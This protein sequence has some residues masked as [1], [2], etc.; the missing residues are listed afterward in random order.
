MKSAL[1][2][3]VLL[4]VCAVSQAAADRE[5]SAFDPQQYVRNKI[6]LILGSYSDFHDAHKRASA[7]SRA[8]K[9]PF[10]M[11]GMIYDKRRGLILPDD[12]SNPIHSGSYVH[13]RYNTASLSEGGEDTEFIS[14]ERSEAYPRFV[15]GYYVVVGGIYDKPKEAKAALSVFT[16]FVADAYIKKTEIYMGCIH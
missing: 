16:P 6:V 5:E 8:S 10:S 13:R 3:I 14:I 11:Q 2:L 9:R 15:P 7:I 4:A 1:L 12:A